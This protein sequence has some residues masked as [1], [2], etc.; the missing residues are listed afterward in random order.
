MVAGRPEYGCRWGDGRQVEPLFTSSSL[1]AFQHCPRRYFWSYVRLRKPSSYDYPIRLGNAVHQVL[2][3][4]YRTRSVAAA[5]TAAAS[6]EA[7]QPRQWWESILKSYYQKYEV[8]IDEALDA[9][10]EEEFRVRLDGGISFGGRI[11]LAIGETLIDHKS[12]WRTTPNR[13][14]RHRS[15]EQLYCY[16]FA[17]TSRGHPVSTLVYNVVIADARSKQRFLRIE[18]PVDSREL[19]TMPIRIQRCAERIIETS[20]WKMMQGGRCQSCLYEPLCRQK[21]DAD[22]S[23]EAVAAAG[24]VGKT[25]QHEELSQ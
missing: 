17:L 2:E 14:A 12:T 10:V 15:W 4:L 19:G 21:L 9:L 23:D 11:D 1:S 7:V 6:Y 8:E 22:A 20:D 3:T 13:W 5:V 24:F 18:R 16:A 25:R